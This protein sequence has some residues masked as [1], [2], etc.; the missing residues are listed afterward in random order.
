M[1]SA[2]PFFSPP[3]LPPPTA[4]AL[5]SAYPLLARFAD[6]NCEGEDG[7]LRAREDGGLR[8]REEGDGDGESE[9]ETVQSG[10]IFVKVPPAKG[11]G[12]RGLDS[13]DHH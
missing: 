9:G 2:F 1:N 13:L 10:R 12:P 8:A 7:G 3:S 4:P 11:L 6:D 5:A